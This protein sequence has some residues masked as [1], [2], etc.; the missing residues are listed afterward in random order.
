MSQLM[1][2]SEIA[3]RLGIKRTQVVDQWR[4]EHSDFPPPAAVRARTPLWR[5]D[6]IERWAR[7]AG[8][9]V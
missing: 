3:R 7:Q 4:R 1:E 2:A 8:V 5:W 6:E 9:R